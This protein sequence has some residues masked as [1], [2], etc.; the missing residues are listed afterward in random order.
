MQGHSVSNTIPVAA[1]NRVGTEG[2]QTFYGTSFITD[3]TG[4]VLADLDRTEEGVVLATIDLDHVDR[5][6]AAWGFFRDRRTDLY[7]ALVAP[8]PDEDPN[9]GAGSSR[10]LVSRRPA[11]GSQ[12]FPRA[13]R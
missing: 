6:R 7:G 11:R 1:A 8:Q 5:A 3:E 10:A 4:E 12:G 9:T 2:Q 13:F